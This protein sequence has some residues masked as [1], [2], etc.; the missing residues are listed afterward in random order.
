MRRYHRGPVPSKGFG[1]LGVYIRM[2]PPQGTNDGAIEALYRERFH[3]YVHVASAITGEQEAARDAVQEAFALALQRQSSLRKRRSL[4]SWIWRIVVRRSIDVTRRRSKDRRLTSAPQAPLPPEDRTNGDDGDVVKRRARPAGAAASGAV[5]P[6]LRRP[7]L[8][9]DR[10]DPRR[11][12]GHG[13]GGAPRSPHR[14]RAFH[15][16]GRSG[17]VFGGLRWTLRI[18][19]GA[20]RP[21]AAYLVVFARPSSL[22]LRLCAPCRTTDAGVLRRPGLWLLIGSHQRHPP[23]VEVRAAGGTLR[24]QVKP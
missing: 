17:P 23:R 15:A 7:R 10:P 2:G 19:P 5:P 12:R 6:L 21:T 20:G 11:R 24:F 3:A 18:R 14:V 8:R 1:T 9:G 22:R 4:E 16:V 13:R